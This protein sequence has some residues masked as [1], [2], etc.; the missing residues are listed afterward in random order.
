MI[1]DFLSNMTEFILSMPINLIIIGVVC[2]IMRI[3]GSTISSLIRLFI[4]YFCICFILATFG[5]SL[6]SIPAV[7]KWCIELFNQIRYM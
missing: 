7:I 5:L 4:G 6:P 1:N 2:I 3:T